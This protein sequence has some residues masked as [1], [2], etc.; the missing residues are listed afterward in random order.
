[1]MKSLRHILL[2]V[3]A[4]AAVTLSCV[5]P[6]EPTPITTGPF[7][8][9]AL[10][11][12]PQVLGI[13]PA[14]KTPGDE[15]FNRGE[16]K[17]TRIDVF[18]Y[19]ATTPTDA[20]FPKHY[21]IGDGTQALTADGE[22][23][24]LLES[25]WRTIYNIN[26][27]YHV[28]T[29]ANIN[30]N[31]FNDPQHPDN[32]TDEILESLTEEQLKKLTS[33]SLE[34]I[35]TLY[36]T[37]YDIV[38]LRQ[39][40]GHDPDP[41]IPADD[42]NGVKTYDHHIGNKIFSMDGSNFSWK[43][44]QEAAKQYIYTKASDKTFELSRAAAKFRVVLDFSSSFKESLGV[45]DGTGLKFTTVTAYQ[46]LVDGEGQPVFDE[47]NQPVQIPKTERI[48]TIG[49]IAKGAD[50]HIYAN[51]NVEGG[52]RAKFANILK[53]TYNVAPE[54]KTDSSVPSASEQD[55]FRDA[56]LWDS[57]DFYEFSFRTSR[58]D[59]ND[60]FIGYK[61]P[62]IDTTYSYAFSWNPGEAAEKAPALAVSI[63]YT[64]YTQE[65][66]ADGS[67]AGDAV[68]DGDG[69]G[70][71][72]YYRIP[73]VDITRT[74]A[75]GNSVKR[76][77]YY[78]VTAEIN[79]MGTSIT[80]IEPTKVNLKYKVIPWP[81]AP[82]EKTEAQTIQ[83]L[84][85]VPEKEYRLR[86]DGLQFTN[87]QYFTPKSDPVTGGHYQSTPKIKN[88]EVYYYDQD[89]QKR[90]IQTA[91]AGGYSWTGSDA[92]GVTIEVFSNANGNGRFYVSSTALKNRSVKYIEF[93]AEVD[94]SYAGGQPVTQHII[95]THF[96][97][98]NIQS[99]LGW[100]SSRWD[101]QPISG[102]STTYF[103][104]RFYKQE[105]TPVT[106][107]EAVWAAGVGNNNDNRR[108]ANSAAT[109]VNGYFARGGSQTTDEHRAYSWGW[110]D[111]VSIQSYSWNGVTVTFNGTRE[112]GLGGTTSHSWDYSNYDYVVSYD[113]VNG[114]AVINLWKYTNYYHLESQRVE[115]Y[116]PTGPDGTWTSNDGFDWVV[117]TQAEYNN[118]APENRKVETIPNAPG[119]GT[120]V[121]YDPAKS[122]YNQGTVYTGS[123]TYTGDDSNAGYYAKVWES[124]RDNVRIHRITPNGEW[125]EQANVSLDNNKNN[126]HM[127]VIQ[128]SK[129]ESGVILGR[130][131]INSTTH[132]SNDNVVSPAFMIASQLG[133]VSSA[134][135]DASSAAQH[136]YT[137]ME[138]SENGRRFVGWRLPTKAEIAYI[139]GYQN[140][141]NIQGSGVFSNVLTGAYYYTL[142]GERAPTYYDDDDDTYVRC[143]R[144][145]TPAEVIE[146]NNTGKI[147]AASY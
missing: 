145:L 133:A 119:T 107:T 40:E 15:D 120:W 11:F 2:C 125:G 92:A 111:I 116:N 105:L 17:V 146:L 80:D 115:S 52:A 112:Y 118:S 45:D 28:Y 136:C 47:N 18:V 79:T 143:I 26:D 5:D 44:D 90:V 131:Q 77:H 130:P 94:F 60:K 61:Y 86:G 82:D 6:L 48:I 64:T 104:K 134:F 21:K 113:V 85:F 7:P 122:G 65:Y 66:N 32:P 39:F 137:Y 75:D 139:V 91:P 110:R 142:D 41:L 24:Y 71:T 16:N 53:S 63:V 114:Y 23:E 69:K 22:V 98:D 33:E 109:A 74:D 73:L 101:Q 108:N 84:Y 36:N 123:S 46:D 54:G 70:I 93:D 128:I 59:D 56:N 76:N 121:A 9:D 58:Y 127:Y 126:P 42:A 55:A 89:G 132:Q 3:L 147:T 103:R 57:Q 29:I 117:C 68:A 72:N 95:V 78:Q 81:D 14:T 96:P 13:T 8:S 135:Y 49:Y 20:N 102:S 141:P 12:S 88:V 100:W 38:R 99:I 10:V 35:G 124:S 50:N 19:N 37:C 25:N 138:V 1:M 129:A 30:A 62:Y 140:D 87:L 106:V 67:F 97:L 51:G 31:K 27:T 83:L 34:S 144:D 43:I 4:L